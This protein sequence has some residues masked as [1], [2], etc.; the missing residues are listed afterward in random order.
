[1]P[2]SPRQIHIEQIQTLFSNPP[3]LEAVAL[4]S[5]QA[6]LDRQLPGRA[7]VAAHLYLVT[8]R[9]QPLSELLVQRLADARPTLLVEGHHRVVQRVRETYAP[10]GPSLA[11]LERLINACGPRL[12]AAFAERLQAWWRETLP[13]NTSRWGHLA[14][15]LLGLLYDSPPPAGMSAQRFGEVFP[16]QGLHGRRADLSVLSLYLRRGDATQMLPLLVIEHA[17]YTVLFSPASGVHVLDNLD[18]VQPLLA[19]YASPLL[20]PPFTQWFA[21]P[22]QGD[23]FEALAAACLARQVQEIASLDQRVPRS[24]RDYQQLL[25]YMVDPR[26]WFV[27]S[28]SASQ[29]ALRPAL[30]LWLAEADSDDSRAAASLLNALIL[31]GQQDVLE[32]IEPLPTFAANRLRHCLQ[33]D[34]RAAALNP[35]DIS[36]TFDRVIAAAVPVPGGFIAGQVLSVSVSLTQLALENL[37]GFPGS[38]KSIQLKGAAAP[39]WLTNATLKACVTRADVGQAYP[40]LLN[41]HLLDD[42]ADAARRQHLFSGQWRA[43]LPLQALVWKIQGLHGLT[44]MGFRRLLAA[45][46]AQP[47][48]RVVE[49]QAVALWPL[50]FKARPSDSADLV[51]GHF[52]I[53][54]RQGEDGPHL[55]YR[56]L[57]TPALL[58]YPSQ[59]AL[60]AAIQAKGEVQDTLLAWIAPRRQAV[61]ANDG[62]RQPHIRY[63]L[64]GDEFTPY[65]PPAPVQLSRQISDSDP[66][67]QVFVATAQ[68]L[69]TLADRHTVSN[70]EQ[71]WASL[72]QAGWLLFNSLMPLLSGPL[73]LGGWLLQV[74]DS[75]RNDLPALSSTDE[76]ARSAAVLD[77]LVN[78]M[79]ILAHQA[80]PHDASAALDIEHSRF[81]PLANPAAAVT[82][83]S[84]QAPAAF[85]APASWANARNTLTPPLQARVD[86]LSV[87][88]SPVGSIET[89]GPWRGLYR[90]ATDWQARVRG[91]TFRVRIERQRARVI[92]ADGTRPGP[93]LK[94]LG[95]GVWDF[96]WQLRLSGGAGDSVERPPTYAQALENDYR[97]AAQDRA[98]AQA[99][100]EVARHLANQPEGT[101]DEH[102][103]TRAQGRYT[104][105][106]ND[107]L[108][109]AQL[110][111]QWLKRLRDLAPRPRYEEELCPVLE[112]IILSAQLLDAQARAQMLTLNNRMR[113]L[114]GRDPQKSLQQ[115]HDE[116]AQG[117][118]E[119]ADVHDSTIRWRTL[120]QRVVEELK[121]VPRLGR[122]RAH[123]L[124]ANIP[125]RPSILELQALQVTTLWTIA[126]DVPGQMLEDD[127]FAGMAA[128]I[129]RARWASHSQADMHQVPSTEAERIELLDSLDHVYA[130][131]DDRIEFWRAVEPDTFNLAYLQ[132]L[133]ELLA[134]LHRQVEHDLADLL[135]PPSAPAPRPASQVSGG[136]RKKIIRTRNRDLYVAQVNEA[137]AQLHDAGGQVIGEFTEAEDGVWDAKEAPQPVRPD[138]ELGALLNKAD[139]L[140]LGVDK[141]IAS[142]ESQVGQANEAQSLQGILEAEARSRRWA[143]E[144]IDRKLRGLDTTRL[145]AVQRAKAR[146]KESELRTAAARLEAAGVSARIRASRH[147]DLSPDDVA[148]LQQQHE[149]RISRQGERVALKGRRNDYLQVYRVSD[150]HTGQALCFAHFH[151][152]RR[153][154]PD[155]HFTAAHLKSVNEQY[156]GRQAQAAVEA[157]AFA[158][159]RSGQTGRVQ[160]TLG[161]RR[162]EIP[163]PLARR[164]FFSVD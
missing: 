6:W 148:F 71:R 13:V 87:A 31:A 158:Q 103:R 102:Q 114:L 132:R 157:H 152:D 142:I 61:Y 155:D 121:N 17:P 136:R 88:S 62:F 15:D 64:Q 126:I 76:Q 54:P 19:A 74:M 94:P 4:D 135:Q 84:T 11:E 41:K 141:A 24:V 9:Y 66:A 131:T 42:H 89:A 65:T 36:L 27:P 97:Q 99:T 30:P 48:Q 57:F 85:E 49:G 73:M 67:Q 80:A 100:M 79:A 134:S 107:K 151:Y 159:M 10:G 117:M 109:F 43:Q 5:A 116:L 150:A 3:S 32:G 104:Q 120:E 101:L 70:A 144:A 140:L 90:S 83:E 35:D 164:L 12:L 145:A 23:P 110:E 37:G 2:A 33:E 7:W 20:V 149:V 147:A 154:G 108:H 124:T 39:A 52:I 18:A 45:V 47:A 34:P 163:L 129:D 29:Q 55:L 68:A 128:T 28:L 119:L 1:M 56:P 44:H 133:Q 111:L 16:K 86:A 160:Q 115:I 122:D 138:P 40:A 26:R 58:E 82:L 63:F 59:H 38:A 96:D 146:V 156:L 51:E 93:W 22:M 98:R 137:S 162:V 106:L 8:E 112:S 123:G 130:Q 81:A 153:Q 75:A 118:R 25:G 78:L 60:F 92:S 139:R 14:D 50:A 46:Q 95:N 161:I 72:K 69:V 53:G 105:A 77:L 113:P 127:F 91:Q 125:P 21:Q 143:A